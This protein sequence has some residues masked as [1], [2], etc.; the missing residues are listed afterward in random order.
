MAQ[1]PDD[2]AALERDYRQSARTLFGH[3]VFLVACCVVTIVLRRFLRMPPALLGVALIVALIVFG[4]DIMKFFRA[5][6][7]VRALRETHSR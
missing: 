6:D 4:A 7:R 3:F 5:R 1:P 2:P